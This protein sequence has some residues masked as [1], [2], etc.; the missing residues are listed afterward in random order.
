MGLRGGLGTAEEQALS[1][2]AMEAE[3]P[4]FKF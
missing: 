3:S 2:W 1:P 4:A